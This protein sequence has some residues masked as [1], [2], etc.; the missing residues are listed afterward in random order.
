MF[1]LSTI[2]VSKENVDFSQKRKI[3]ESKATTTTTT[4]IALFN[5]LV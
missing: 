3:H 2:T 1:Y 4:N 5:Q